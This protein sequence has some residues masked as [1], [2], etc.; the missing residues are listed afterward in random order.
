MAVY[1]AET[2]EEHLRRALLVPRLSAMLFGI[3]GFTG[4]ALALRAEEWGLVL[5]DRRPGMVAAP[6]KPVVL[7]NGNAVQALALRGA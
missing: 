7:Q 3:L 2:M 5:V 6:V 1:T 4:R